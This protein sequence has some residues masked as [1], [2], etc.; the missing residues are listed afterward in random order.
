MNTYIPL[1]VIARVVR[2]TDLTTLN[3]PGISFRAPRQ[4]DARS[5]S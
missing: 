4:I 5:I 2:F 1:L 3:S